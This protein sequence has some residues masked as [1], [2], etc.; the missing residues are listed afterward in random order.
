MYKFE[1]TVL[2]P[3]NENVKYAYIE[4]LS[5]LPMNEDLILILKFF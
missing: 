3:L 2:L 5:S 4:S 1:L